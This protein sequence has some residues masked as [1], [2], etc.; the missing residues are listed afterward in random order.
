MIK[1]IYIHF[2]YFIQYPKKII[3]LEH[4]IECSIVRET[5]VPTCSRNSKSYKISEKTC[6]SG[7][8]I[9]IFF[10]LFTIK[11]VATDYDWI[12]ALNYIFKA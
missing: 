2:I 11:Y 12:R 6:C 9:R 1:P 3:R 4:Y 10:I 8:T 5:A 7:K